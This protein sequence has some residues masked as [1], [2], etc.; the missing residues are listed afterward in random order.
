MH[1]TRAD[2][3]PCTHQN[4]ARTSSVLYHHYHLPTII[5]ITSNHHTTHVRRFQRYQRHS[6]ALQEVIRCPVPHQHN[7]RVY[8]R[9]RP[10]HCL[11]LA[12]PRLSPPITP[13]IPTSVGVPLPHGNGGCNP[14][15][16]A[17]RQSALASARVLQGR[18]HE[19]SLRRMV[20]PN[21]PKST[22]SRAPLRNPFHNTIRSGR[23]TR[24]VENLVIATLMAIPFSPFW[25]S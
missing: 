13:T 25:R 6:H 14:H 19:T 17:T 10:P 11:V 4:I 12:V 21:D 18:P 23:T 1:A 7:R 5:S 20:L 22:F 8:N 15:S 24:R 9:Q 16:R 3:P 2:I